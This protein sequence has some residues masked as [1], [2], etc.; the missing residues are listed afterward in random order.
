MKLAYSEA[1]D[2]TKREPRA[3][4]I[5][6]P[7]HSNAC[8]CTPSRASD[9]ALR[10][11]CLLWVAAGRRVSGSHQ[12][13]L[14]KLHKEQKSRLFASQLPQ[15]CPWQ[16]SISSEDLL[17]FWMLCTDCTGRTT[18]PWLGIKKKKRIREKGRCGLGT[19]ENYSKCSQI[20]ME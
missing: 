17:R 11:R 13:H 5:H 15:I 14:K 16:R 1:F 2:F 10:V 18:V 7:A 9:G 3:F 8:A 12:S 4:M 20:R 19:L 6:H